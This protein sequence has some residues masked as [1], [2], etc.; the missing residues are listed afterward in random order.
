M[1]ALSGHS[2][3]QD[4]LVPSPPPLREPPRTATRT[5][6]EPRARQ[7]LE[8]CPTSPFFLG[9]GEARCAVTRAVSRP[10]AELGT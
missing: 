7:G 6:S 2:K 5:L 8:P 9:G 4:L 10:R 3:E 1:L